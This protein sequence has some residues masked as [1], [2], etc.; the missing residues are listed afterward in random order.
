RLPDNS[1]FN[2]WVNQLETGG[3]TRAQAVM[4]FTDAAKTGATTQHQLD[5]LNTQNDYADFVRTHDGYN[6]DT[7]TLKEGRW[8]AHTTWGNN[9]VQEFWADN[10]TGAN[11]PGI[12]WPANSQ[13]SSHLFI[14]DIRFNGDQQITRD[15]TFGMRSVDANANFTARLD[16][17]SFVAAAG[18]E[19]GSQLNLRL[20]DL[21]NAAS[22][23]YLKESPYT[24]FHFML[25]G[26]RIDVT[27]DAIN[28]AQTYDELLIAIREAVQ[29]IPA[30]QNFNVSF[31]PDFTRSDA[32]G[33]FHT[34]KTI[35]LTNTGEGRIDTGGWIV[36]PAGIP[37]DSNLVAQQDNIEPGRTS[38][39]IETNIVLDDA[40]RGSLAGTLDVGAM[41]NSPLGIERFN[42]TVDR[43][44]KI[45][46]LKT[47]DNKLQD[48]FIESTGA[49][50]SL[51]IGGTQD[52]LLEINA[53]AFEGASLSLGQ[54]TTYA[55]GV[56][57]AI[58]NLATL[59]A[60][61]IS[62]N[63]TFVG[64][65]NG[66]HRATI[67]TGTGND[68]ITV[69]QT[70]VSDSGSTNTSSVITIGGGTNT[71]VLTGGA[72]T[73]S[74]ITTGT[75][76]DTIHGGAVAITARTGAGNDVIY[77]DNT[78]AKASFVMAA[79]NAVGVA[80]LGQ[81]TTAGSLNR[82]VE[83]VEL[84]NG[85]E[86]QITL[87]IPGE[88][89]AAFEDGFEV[90]TIVRASNGV[91]TTERDLYNAVANAI[92]TDA[93][94]GKLASARV[95]SNGHLQVQYLVDGMTADADELLQIAV[96]GDW[97]DLA[98]GTRTNL[99]DAIELAKMD[100]S[101]TAG[102]LETLFD[103][104]AVGA[105]QSI[106][107]G[108]GTQIVA[109]QAETVFTLDLAALAADDDLIFTFGGETITVPIAADWATNLD[110]ASFTVGGV[111]FLADLTAGVWTFTTTAGTAPTGTLTA[112]DESDDSVSET[113][114]GTAL[115]SV[116][117]AAGGL[118]IINAGTGNDL[119]V[120]NSNADVIDVVV[121]DSGSFGKNTIVHFDDGA[122]Q[123]IL[124]FNFL[125]NLEQLSGS[126]SQSRDYFDTDI[127]A[128][129]AM[130]A[131]T[132]SV[133][134]FTTLNNGFGTGPLTFSGLTD[135]QVQHALN[136]TAAGGTAATFSANDEAGLVANEL[137]S[138]LL[139]ENVDNEGEYKVV[140]VTA[141]NSAAGVDGD[142]A[143]TGAR[144][145]GT[146]DFGDTIT[147]A[148]GENNVL[149]FA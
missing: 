27:S 36:G 101:I 74:V 34:G 132:V 2:W 39:K 90:K 57:D 145:V 32:N 16:S 85:R 111:E 82:T 12:G 92:N 128:I 136:G 44:S 20:M 86:I 80:G 46:E 43:D 33:V 25:A 50:G 96:L 87:A 105:G 102:E 84:L 55:G 117:N 38:P 141:S 116:S 75:G 45:T 62:T 6:G 120:L 51:Y 63:V 83:V 49:K 31:G 73:T 91:I 47:T 66:G 9:K 19:S 53:T 81:D 119:I 1:G 61:G 78:G 59:N 146:L 149:G 76:A 77:A 64:A 118:N 106:P 137:K 52:G 58:V 35:V 26:Q 40:G 110:N 103:T 68:L 121:I 14:N 112:T 98:P 67:N 37:G 139:I 93:V 134:D 126:S 107:A 60:G 109:T 30:L 148:V 140:E 21:N 113:Q 5:Y 48:I 88:E 147:L 72:N 4:A 56:N 127:A 69:N 24:G 123:D 130:S 138:I 133:T 13:G 143:F 104:A 129:T 89:A 114:T 42:V 94:L 41:S 8:D 131:N 23:E 97:T 124:K 11:N 70:G 135:A 28:A 15:F 3:F 65:N 122:N 108:H 71:V 142:T 99:L 115:G 18:D 100:S 79:N 54:G 95:D 22:G 125:N 7:V 17:Q 10:T 144:I 29:Q